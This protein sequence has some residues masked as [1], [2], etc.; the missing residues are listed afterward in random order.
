MTTINTFGSLPSSFAVLLSFLALAFS[1]YSDNASRRILK[2]SSGVQEVLLM[3]RAG[4]S[5]L[6]EGIGERSN[7]PSRAA[8]YIGGWEDTVVK[9]VE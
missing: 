4:L 2:S 7:S 3:R 9:G 5:S 6:F 1:S 8:E